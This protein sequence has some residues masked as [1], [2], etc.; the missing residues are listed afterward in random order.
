[1]QTEGIKGDRVTKVEVVSVCGYLGA[2]GLAKWTHVY[3]EKNEINC[4]MRLG[5]AL[6]DMFGRCGDPQSA[7][8]VFDNMARRDVSAWTAAIG[9]MVMQG[10]GERALELFDDMLKQGVKPDEVVFEAV[11]STNSMQ[12]Y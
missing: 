9:A 12:P 8:K 11:P 7:M 6:F 2:L 5:T 1:M 3:I 10:N 4:D